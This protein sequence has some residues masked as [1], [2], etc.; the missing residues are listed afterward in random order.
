MHPT[1]LHIPVAT[2]QHHK[3]NY[4]VILDEENLA[5]DVTVVAF[6][7]GKA[8]ADATA[9]TDKW[10]DKESNDDVTVP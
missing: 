2:H 5:D 9:T 10:T 3:S 4:S 6:N 8:T 1:Q 7:K